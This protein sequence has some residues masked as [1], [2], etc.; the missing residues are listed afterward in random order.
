MHSER[1]NEMI[2]KWTKHVLSKILKEFTFPPPRLLA[3]ETS[4]NLK[5]LIN[6]QKLTSAIILNM[7]SADGHTVTQNILQWTGNRQHL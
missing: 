4:A 2:N 3:S 5:Q 1:N 7:L 6:S